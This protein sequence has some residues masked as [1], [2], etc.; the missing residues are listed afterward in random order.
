[1]ALPASGSISEIGKMIR[2]QMVVS[3][4]AAIVIAIAFPDLLLYGVLAMLVALLANGLSALMLMRVRG[5]GADLESGLVMLGEMARL[6]VSV[7]GL[8]L[9]SQLFKPLPDGALWMMVATFFLGFLSPAA[10]QM[11]TKTV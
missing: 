10:S 2:F 8:V 9:L 11:I 4:L 5:R 7:G 3:V 1:M 6:M